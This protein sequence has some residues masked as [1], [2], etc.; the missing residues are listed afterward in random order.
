MMK[1][2]GIGLLVTGLV[3]GACTSAPLAKKSTADADLARRARIEAE[4][5]RFI[6]HLGTPVA[7]MLEEKL[8]ST[9]G[10]LPSAAQKDA[11]QAVLSYIE[12]QYHVSTIKSL[13]QISNL[14]E[15]QVKELITQIITHPGLFRLSEDLVNEGFAAELKSYAETGKIV[16]DDVV[17]KNL[18]AAYAPNEIQAITNKIYEGG[19]VAPEVP[20]AT[21]K[22]LTVELAD[23]NERAYAALGE[24]MVNLNT[25][26]LA[27][28][29]S[30]DATKNVIDLYE[31]QIRDFKE[32]GM[33]AYCYKNS[34]VAKTFDGWY[35]ETLGGAA[36]TQ[37][38]LIVAEGNHIMALN[39]ECALVPASLGNVGAV[40]ANTK[41]LPFVAGCPLR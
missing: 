36:A 3:L 9:I 29:L 12:K 38:E 28:G 21:R 23:V 40:M 39:K 2:S 25:C 31:R 15:K 27:Q 4:V 5:D 37:E 24:P 7:K 14:P 34:G 13:D 11:S 26:G 17:A 22:K 20:L 1:K 10:L 6:A 35:R 19:L 32:S 18:P 41:A 8:T 30:E 16:A 33:S